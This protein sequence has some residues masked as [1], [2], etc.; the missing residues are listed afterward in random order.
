VASAWIGSTHNR[1][2]A[3]DVTLVEIKTNKE[4]QMPTLFDDF[5]EKAAHSYLDLPT[6]A[7][8]NRQMLLNVMTKNGFI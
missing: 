5:S 7:K 4:L 3:V 1:G 2:C 8:V 6:E